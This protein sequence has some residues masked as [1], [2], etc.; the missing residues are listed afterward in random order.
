MN[1]LE[2]NEAIA[3][4]AYHA[5]CSFFA[6]YP[7]TPAT[8]ILNAVLRLLPPAGGLVVQA[9]DEIAAIGMCLGAS[10]AGKKAM[11]ATS[12]PGISLY[13]ENLSF[14]IGSEIP[15]VVVDVMR[16]GP[17]TGS[18]TRA[19]DGDVQFLRWG[20]SGGLP[21]ICLAPVDVADCYTLTLHAFNLAETYRCPVF[22]APNKDIGLTRESVDLAAVERP[23]PV[24][25][26]LCPRDEPY[27]PFRPAPGSDVPYFLP[28]GGD[29]LSRQTS[30]THGENG[31]ITT[32]PEEISAQVER[33]QRKLE[34]HVDRFSYCDS[35]LQPG[36]DTLVLTYGA[37]GRAA[38]QACR[39]LA[40]EGLPTS[41]AV[42]KTLWPVPEGAI[43]ALAREA[44]RVLVVELNL[45]QYVHEV[46]RVLPRH[47]VELL[48]QMN[49][50]LITPTQIKE[51]VRG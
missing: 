51:A 16:L 44:R 49:G 30:S 1:F 12:G 50:T 32:D 27:L 17:S 38:R 41:L 46:Q 14:A 36:A 13:S 4:G 43:R 29:R 47:R 5:G 25:R 37:S 8:G 21:A 42:L 34:A 33:L 2:G 48:G 18:A 10:M 28:I 40:A 24:E 9:E 31:F 39:E 35:A 23:V 22:L 3:W 7:I 26:R 19:A 11:T 20:N 45:G 15:L 6:G